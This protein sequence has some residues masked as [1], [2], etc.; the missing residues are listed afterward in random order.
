MENDP[1]STTPVNPALATPET[2]VTPVS[3]SSP[4]I[5]AIP[6]SPVSPVSAVEPGQP[7]PAL[8]PP[9]AAK[10]AFGDGM[11]A[12]QWGLF[13]HL[14]QLLGLTVVPVLGY[15]AP[16]IIWQTQKSPFPALDSHGKMVTNWMISLLIYSLAAT[17]IGL[18]TCGT[19]F[20]LL[21]PLG[22]VAVVFPIIGGIKANEGVLWT[23]PGTIP[24]MR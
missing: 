16:I 12:N 10:S 6:V 9:V 24:F 8:P 18:A 22:I 15:V 7:P 1:Q 4:A 3:P 11:S 20:L 14:S 23:Y 17:V 5:P 2:P 13:L 21:I 19:G